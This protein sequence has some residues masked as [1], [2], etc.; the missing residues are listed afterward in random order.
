M[1]RACFEHVIVN[2]ND[3][4]KI[5]NTGTRM[6]DS[7]LKLSFIHNVPIKTSKFGISTINDVKKIGVS[8]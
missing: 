5:N 7:T 8:S 4:E 1:T 3:F 6:Q 2:P